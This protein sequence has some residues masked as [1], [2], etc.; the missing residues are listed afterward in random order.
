MHGQKNITILILFLL[1]TRSLPSYLFPSGFPTKRRHV[2]RFF[3]IHSACPAQLVL[4]NWIALI[5]TRGSS[6]VKVLFYKSESCWFDP[7]WCNWNFS[8]T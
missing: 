8:L 6:V 5:A 2:F 1:S 7:S 4:F 3:L